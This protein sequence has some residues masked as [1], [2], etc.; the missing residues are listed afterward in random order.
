MAMTNGAN[1]SLK[2]T[3][4][5]ADAPQLIVREQL[6]VGPGAKLIVDARGYKGK[7]R[8]VQLVK[9]ARG[10]Y[11]NPYYQGWGFFRN[12]K[13]SAWNVSDEVCDHFDENCIETFGDVEILQIKD[14]PDNTGRAAGIWAR[15]K[16]GLS[17]IV[18]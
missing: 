7:S 11:P 13:P 16:H 4:S 5:G 15:V 10:N 6:T 1:S 2:F 9:F 17:V 14:N 12:G 8:W 18:K 3:L